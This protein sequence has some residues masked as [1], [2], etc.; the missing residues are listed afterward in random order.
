MYTDHQQTMLAGEDRVAA[1]RYALQTLTSNFERYPYDART[2]VYL[3]H[4]LD[5]APPEEVVDETFLRAVLG[6]A[7]ELSPKRIQ[8]HYIM[9]NISLKKGD[10]ATNPIQRNQYYRDAIGVL[11]EYAR[12]VPNLAEPRFIIAGLYV[13]V[14]DRTSGKR[15][16]DEG[17]AVYKAD[18]DT[19]RRAV[20]Y[21]LAVEDWANVAR[22]LGD[23]VAA[24]STDYP[25]MYDLAKAEFLTGNRDRALEIFEIVREK[26]PDLVKTDPA[27]L[28]AIGQ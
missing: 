13:V 25:S 4:V 21:Y 11:E 15:W 2:A 1:Y 5:S 17:L 7:I 8:P 20:R 19:A 10:K 6:R 28:K 12:Q 22:F 26:A 23:V 27:F 3:A 14:G 18:G 9:S 16:A 24:D